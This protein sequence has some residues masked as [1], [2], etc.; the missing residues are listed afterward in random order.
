MSGNNAPV[1]LFIN[2]WAQKMGGAEH[3]LGDILAYA[4]GRCECHLS[5]TEKG[6]LTE[7]AEHAGVATHIVCCGMSEKR[8][9]REKIV[10][11]V[12]F[13]LKDVIMFLGYVLRLRSLVVKLAPDL[14]HANVPKSHVALFFL[15]RLGYKGRCCF[16]MREIFS[17]RSVPFFLYC[18]LFPKRNAA[19]LA[20]SQAVKESLPDRLQRRCTVIYNGVLVAKKTYTPCREGQKMRLL[21]LGR[22]VPWKGCHI[23]V[24]IFSTLKLQYPAAALE[25]SLV[26]DT[27]YWP[28][29]Y[30]QKL[31]QTIAK[32]GLAETCFL[33]PHTS[34]VVSVLFGHDVFCNASY[35]EPFGRSIAEA[36]GAGLPAVSFD[37]GGVREIVERDE[38]GFLV[39]YGDKDAFVKAL[40]RFVEKPDLIREMGE[41]AH[42]R[43]KMHF[44]RVVQAPKII[45]FLLGRRES[46]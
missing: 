8:F 39:P 15:S 32:K 42:E 24:D 6:A 7:A 40:G 11:G 18:L 31:E 35:L 2:H 23:L 17:R 13:S 29:E 43:A 38:T 26:G 25:L 12:L 9:L 19:V 37:S 33:L 14:I 36:Q 34:D 44:N 22:V 3:S 10:S 1:L 45:D 16:H 4:A 21:Y 46:I 41:R 5:T 27:S 20:I 28:H 30:R